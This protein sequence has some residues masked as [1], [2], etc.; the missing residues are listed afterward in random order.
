VRRARTAGCHACCLLAVSLGWGATASA[1]ATYSS[2][3]IGGRSALMGGTG[4]ALGRDGAAPFLNPAT[5]ASIDDSGAFSMNLYSFQTATLSGFHQPG[6]VDAARYG[7]LS[8]PNTSLDS[9]RVDALPS[10]LCFVLTV[11]GPSDD[12]KDAR[13]HPKGRRKG[14]FC[15]TSPERLQVSAIADGYAGSSA[16]TNVTQATSFAQFWNRLYVGPS[17]SVYVTDRV[18]LGASILGVGTVANSTWSVDSVV[19][20]SNGQG[21]AS[22]YATGASAWSMD[23]AALLGLTWRIDDRQVLGVG[24]MTPSAHVYGKYEGTT[25]L[26]TQDAGSSATM[27]TSQGSYR[28]TVPLRVGAGIGADLGRVRVEGDLAAYLP[29][30]DLAHAQVQ[31]SQTGLA[32]GA[33][34]SSSFAQTLTVAG[35]PV[36]DAA[37]GGELF[38]SRGFSLLGGLNTDFSAVAPLSPSPAIG[39]LVEARTHHAA[40]SLGIGSYG[41]GSELL[42]GTQLSYGWGKNVAVDP[43]ESPAQLS[44]VDERTFGAMLVIA[45]SVSLTAFKRTLQNLQT[46]VKLPPLN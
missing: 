41:D 9:S 32:S 19:G 11:G 27:T 22:S 29:V 25:S 10:T 30:T 26:Q 13:S 36:V 45:G 37:V 40:L 24:V 6:P 5:V 31:T 39:T 42:L 35:R 20:T 3:P 23:V 44:I 1:Q 2:A 38:L 15:V 46:V 18:A 16:G 34:T 28:A 21:F 33:S 4:M 43:Y 14:A 8:L 12:D 17:Y 7:A